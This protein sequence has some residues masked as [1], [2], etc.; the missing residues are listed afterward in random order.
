MRLLDYRCAAVM[1]FP[2]EENCEEDCHWIHWQSRPRS[3][4]A[5]R[6]RHCKQKS[7]KRYKWIRFTQINFSQTTHERCEIMAFPA[8]FVKQKS[9]L[10]IYITGSTI[11]RDAGQC[12]ACFKIFSVYF[13]AWAAEWSRHLANARGQIL[14]DTL[15]ELDIVSMERIELFYWTNV[16]RWREWGFRW[17]DLTFIVVIKSSFLTIEAKECNRRYLRDETAKIFSR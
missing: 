15:V 10:Y 9:T 8:D 12:S 3:S 11:R 1:N 4:R 2:Q 14:L 13:K 5:R 17:T 7:T 6:Y 16:R